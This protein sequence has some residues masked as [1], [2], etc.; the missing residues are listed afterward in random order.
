ML[1]KIGTL[2][3]SEG[4]NERGKQDHLPARTGG[5]EVAKRPA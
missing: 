3:L 1:S 5:A 2:L 4:A